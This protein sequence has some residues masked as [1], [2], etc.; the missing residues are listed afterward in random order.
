MVSVHLVST[1][2]KDSTSKGQIMIPFQIYL[3][4]SQMASK[5]KKC[6]A[7]NASNANQRQLSLFLAEKGG[8]ILKSVLL[9]NRKFSLRSF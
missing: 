6:N 5:E 4:S 1:V 9:E 2:Q 8:F 3:S 7:S